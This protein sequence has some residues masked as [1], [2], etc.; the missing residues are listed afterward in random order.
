LGVL[1]KL[2]AQKV[3]ISGTV[4]DISA[5]KPLEAVAVLSSSGKAVVTDSLGHYHITVNNK[6]S[7][8]FSMI[9][10]TTMKYPVDTINNPLSFDIMIHIKA[11]DLPE[12]KVRN[13]YYRFDSLQN[14]KDYA[15]IFDFKKPGLKLSTNPGFNTTPGV[16]VGIDLDEVIN[17]FRFKRN[18]QILALQTRLLQQEQ[19]KYV[20][21]RY[22]KSLV[23]KLTQLKSPELEQF[24]RDYRPEYA[25]VKTMNELELGYYI[26]KC[27]EAYKLNLPNPF[28][29]VFKYLPQQEEE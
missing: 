27:F 14:R 9:G 10:K 2:S 6:D 7:I 25:W 15:K 20:D 8:W 11:T 5:R 24:M 22:K 1:A 19:D 29:N 28:K 17:M 23:I 13:S 12:V 21:Y 26:Q 3:T 18:R 16:T 4:Y